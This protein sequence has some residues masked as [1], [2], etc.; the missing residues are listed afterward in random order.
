M[1]SVDN[2]AQGL[3]LAL[4]IDVDGAINS[5]EFDD[6]DEFLNSA[7]SFMPPGWRRE[8][9][10]YAQLVPTMRRPSSLG[11]VASRTLPLS[12]SES[13][14][15]R[16]DRED[17]APLPTEPTSEYTYIVIYLLLCLLCFC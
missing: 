8:V 5:G 9:S 10:N 16:R 15:F 6:D 3:P 14:L 4:L 2:L 13:T 7:D 11:T 1:S 12:S 17:P